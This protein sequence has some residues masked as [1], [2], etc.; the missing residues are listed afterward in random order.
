MCSLTDNLFFFSFP[1][2]SDFHKHIIIYF[3]MTVDSSAFQENIKKF[4]QEAKK[5]EQ[6]ETLSSKVRI[7]NKIKVRFQLAVS[8]FKIGSTFKR[9]IQ[10][11]QISKFN[12]LD[13]RYW[14]YVTIF[15]TSVICIIY[16]CLSQDLQSSC[17]FYRTV[18][19]LFQ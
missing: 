16:S 6:S 3:N 11:I 2:R 5:Y 10:G 1:Q 12:L 9:C 13:M 17:C 7:A 15:S 14:Q 8:G 19:H 18:Y 4:Q